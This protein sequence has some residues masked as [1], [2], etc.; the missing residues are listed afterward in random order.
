MNHLKHTHKNEE[1]EPRALRAQ[2]SKNRKTTYPFFGVLRRASG[3]GHLFCLRA[4][5]NISSSSASCLVFQLGGRELLAEVKLS[6][7]KTQKLLDDTPFV[8]GESAK[9]VGGSPFRV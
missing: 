2:G 9:V 5:Y 7:L 6:F 1:R 3:A 8:V 4:P